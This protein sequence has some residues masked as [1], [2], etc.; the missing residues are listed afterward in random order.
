MSKSHIL[1]V[2]TNL[3]HWL[4]QAWQAMA[5]V[6]LTA[7]AQAGT[8]GTPSLTPDRVVAGVSS[9]TYSSTNTSFINRMT[10]KTVTEFACPSVGI[11][12]VASKYIATA[13]TH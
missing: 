1:R 6:L 11:D 2:N 5:L 4:G 7:A 13:K 10:K 12:D 3:G 9:T 8:L